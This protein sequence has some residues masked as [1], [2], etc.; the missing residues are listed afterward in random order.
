MVIGILLVSLAPGMPIGATGI[1][2]GS[3]VKIFR[4]V[5]E[6]HRARCGQKLSEASH[7][8]ICVGFSLATAHCAELLTVGK[9][10]YDSGPG[11]SRKVSRK[12]S[13]RAAVCPGVAGFAERKSVS[14][15]PDLS[16]AS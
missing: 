4:T 9:G 10:N 12:D 6:G 11:D 8:F 14:C 1:S 7:H 2:P 13:S 3:L 5:A 16:E 15:H